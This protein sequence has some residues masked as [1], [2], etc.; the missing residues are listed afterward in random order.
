MAKP[1]PSFELTRKENPTDWQK[2]QMFDPTIRTEFA[3]GD[4]ASRALFTRPLYRISLSYHWLTQ[5]DVTL[6]EQHQEHV[7]VGSSVFDF[8]NPY[9]DE[10]WEVRYTKPVVIKAEPQLPSRFMAS[11]EFFGTEVQKMRTT[12]YEVEDLGAGT[13]ISAREFLV[14]PKAVTINS[15]GIL[16]QGAPANV[17]DANTSVILVEDDAS[18]TIVSKTYNT[19]T[20]PPSSDYEDLGTITN[21]S[22]SA[23]EHL[24]LSV[25]NGATANLPG[26]VIIVEW[27]YTA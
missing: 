21:G 25:T 27:Y 15:I 19:A 13:D 5:A 11:I 16:T 20:Q 18:N 24:T 9:D 23:A 1:F 22:L 17:N 8:R 10:D 6:I 3:S 4:A 7:K 12:Q 14:N 2:T 26:F